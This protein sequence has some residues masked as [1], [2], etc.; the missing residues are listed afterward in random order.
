MRIFLIISIL[1]FLNCNIP[2]GL[3]SKNDY[4]KHGAIGGNYGAEVTVQTKSYGGEFGQN[5]VAVIWIEDSDGKFIKTIGIWALNYPDALV[6]WQEKKST[7]EIDGITSASR[8]NHHDELT[9]RWD[10]RDMNGD[11]VP[12]A[13]YVVKVEFTEDNAGSG[14]TYT[15]S[16]SINVGNNTSSNNGQISEY[17]T[18][19][20]VIYNP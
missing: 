7:D 15:S 11:R 13:S 9:G 20:N 1:F 2:N 12:N 10:L 8:I 4:V 6:T 14:P 17:V 19:F 5:N 3:F 18:K 16:C